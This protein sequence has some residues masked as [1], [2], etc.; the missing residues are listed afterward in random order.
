MTMATRKA[1]AC[2]RV[3]QATRRLV[4]MVDQHRIARVA[5]RQCRSVLIK[6]QQ[7]IVEYGLN[8]YDQAR[9]LRQWRTAH[10][11]LALLDA[12]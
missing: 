2:L 9:L 4:R 3:E 1:H 12:L 11:I 6:E 5:E 8:A 7:I 10:R